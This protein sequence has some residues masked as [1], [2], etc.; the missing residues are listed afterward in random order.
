VSQGTILHLFHW[1]KKFSLPFRDLIHEH[2]PDGRHKFVIYGSVDPGALPVS[3]DTVIYRRLLKNFSALS[4]AMHRAE[5][6]ILHG[7]FDSHLFYTLALQPW[8]IKKCCW[9]IWGGDLYFHEADQKSR[10]WKRFELLRQ[11]VIK[12]LPLITTTVPGDYL[13]ARQW[14]GTKARYIQNIMYTSH[15]S[16]R[17]LPCDDVEK[18]ILVIQI[19]NSAD[20]SNNHK[21][22]I[23]KLSA[24][25][26]DNFVVYA[27]LSYGNKSYSDEIIAYGLSKLGDRFTPMTTFMPFEEY[28]EYLRRIDI[29][30]F[31]HRR[32]QAMGNTIALLSLGKMVWLRSDVTPWNYLIDIGLNIYDSKSQL[33]LYRMPQDKKQENIELCKQVFSEEAL[34]SAW[35]RIF[36]EPLLG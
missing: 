12:R 16:R 6:I 24:L 26:A 4:K 2:F 1:D 8:L 20:P 31:N 15:I 21:E 14:Y 17:V 9:V 25:R 10:D 19:G 27:P 18:D 30:I 29:V 32:Q 3:A 28:N 7:M 23:D 5:K 22:I 13:L 11:F 35:K 36:N 34:L 33:R